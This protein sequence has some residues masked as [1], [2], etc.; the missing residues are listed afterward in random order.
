MKGTPALDESKEQTREA[1]GRERAD[2]EEEY[3]EEV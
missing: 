1:V 2:E 3:K